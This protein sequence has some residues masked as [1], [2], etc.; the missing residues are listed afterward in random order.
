MHIRRFLKAAWP[1]SS[2]NADVSLGILAIL[3][4]ITYTKKAK[5]GMLIVG[6]FNDVFKNLI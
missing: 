3:T 2:S 1:S 4:P 6:L 5:R